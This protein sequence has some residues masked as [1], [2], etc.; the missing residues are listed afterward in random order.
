MTTTTT[1]RTRADIIDDIYECYRE[2]LRYMTMGNY[3]AFERW[4][5]LYRKDYDAMEQRMARLRGDYER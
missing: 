3:I 4:L 2:D 5:A 1:T